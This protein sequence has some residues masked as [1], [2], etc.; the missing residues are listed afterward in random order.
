MPPG[1]S[2]CC[3]P[4]RNTRSGRCPRRC[5]PPLPKTFCKTRCRRPIRTG[6]SRCRRWP[7]PWAFRTPT[8]R[9]CTCPTTRLWGNTARILPTRRFYLKSANRWTPTKRTTRKKPKAVCKRT[10]T[11]AWTSKRCCGPACSIC[12]SATTTGTK[13]SGAGSASTPARA[14]CTNRCPATAT[15]CTTNRPALFRGC[16]RATC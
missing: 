9:W 14:A 16:C 13:T 10:T 7:K 3:A 4:S 11:T 15:T 1:S 5:G 2:G 12:S 6:P 8:R